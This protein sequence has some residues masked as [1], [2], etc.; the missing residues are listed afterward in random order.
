MRVSDVSS[1]NNCGVNATGAG[2]DNAC[3]RQVLAHII[4]GLEHWENLRI[5][6]GDSGVVLSGVRGIDE[7]VIVVV[8]NVLAGNL[9]E[10][11]VRELVGFLEERFLEEQVGLESG[12]SADAGAEQ[13]RDSDSLEHFLK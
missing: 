1:V 11:R 2:A 7:L 12:E 4:L 10:W 5:V 6:G 3:L 13:S 9:G 8:L